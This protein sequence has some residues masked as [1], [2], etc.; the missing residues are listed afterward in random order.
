MNINGKHFTT[1]WLKEDDCKT[2]QVIDQRYLP[3]KVEI[4]EIKTVK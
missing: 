4:V 1:I 2:L 3:H